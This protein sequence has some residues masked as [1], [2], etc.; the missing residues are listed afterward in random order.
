MHIS[1]VISGLG[2]VVAAIGGGVLLA[3]CFRQPR[4]DLIAMSVALIALLISLGSQTLGY[5]DGFDSAMFRAME[6][7]GQVI[8]PLALVLALAEVGARSAPVR[9]CARL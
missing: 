1:L 5:V 7:G 4:S 6:L 3:R 8:A 2:A 9:F